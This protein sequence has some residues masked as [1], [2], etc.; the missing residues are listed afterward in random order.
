MAQYTLGQDGAEEVERARLALLEEVHDPYTVRQFD[1]IGVS[2][3]WR[4]LDVGAGAGSRRGCLRRG[5]AIRARW[6][7]STSTCASWSGLQVIASR[8]AD[9]MRSATLF[10]KQRSILCMPAIC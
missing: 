3:G 1:A 7:R 2:E 10:P 5:W 9:M 8:S 6:S 4:C